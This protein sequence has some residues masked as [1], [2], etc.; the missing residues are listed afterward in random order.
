MNSRKLNNAAVGGDLG[1]ATAEVM[2]NEGISATPAQIPDGAVMINTDLLPSK[3]KYYKNP[4]YVTELS[5]IDLKNL[6]QMTEENANQTINSVLSNCIHGINYKEILQGDKVW[7]LFYIR[8]VT[9]DDFPIFVKY[10]C[11]ECKKVDTYKVRLNDLKVNYANDAFEPDLELPRCGK[12]IT[13]RYPTLRLEERA[14]RLAKND[15]AIEAIDPELAEIALYIEKIDGKAVEP[16]EAYKFVKSMKALDFVTFSNYMIEHN[17]GLVPLVEIPCTCGNIV[18]KKIGF[19][20][21]FFFPD[22]KKYKNL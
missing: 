2:A 1:S 18:K 9:Y 3:G 6:N 17:I 20:P 21:D 14:N 7:L 13:L 12:I 4:L 11:P 22:F 5:P 16:Y 8:S 19:T 15:Q 10:S